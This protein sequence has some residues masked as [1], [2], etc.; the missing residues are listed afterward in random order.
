MSSKNCWICGFIGWAVKSPCRWRTSW[1][2]QK[3]RL[4]QIEGVGLMNDEGYSRHSKTL[5]FIIHS[6]KTFNLTLSLFLKI[7]LVQAS[8]GIFIWKNWYISDNLLKKNLNTSL[9]KNSDNWDI[10]SNKDI[11]RFS[12]ISIN[13]YI[14]YHLWFHQGISWKVRTYWTFFSKIGTISDEFLKIRTSS[15]ISEKLGR[16]VVVLSYCILWNDFIKISPIFPDS[17]FI[18]L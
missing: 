17:S 11:H 2:F 15:Q 6:T 8:Q 18:L 7:Q 4:C 1:I 9:K 3:K 10:F 5:P 14:I 13:C 16:M 12:S